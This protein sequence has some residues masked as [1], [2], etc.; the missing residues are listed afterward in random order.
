MRPTL[1][2][3]I[4]VLWLVYAYAWDNTDYNYHGIEFVDYADEGASSYSDESPDW[5]FFDFW[6]RL[7]G[8]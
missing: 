5:D 3:L 8:H 1:Q 7:L 4:C 2:T 6:R